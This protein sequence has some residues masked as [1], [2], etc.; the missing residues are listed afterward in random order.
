MNIATSPNTGGDQQQELRAV[1]AR[2]PQLS[3][4]QVRRLYD[5]VYGGANGCLH[6]PVSLGAT[7]EA[8][9]VSRTTGTRRPGWS[10]VSSGFPLMWAVRAEQQYARRLTAVAEEAAQ[11]AA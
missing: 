3:A 2:W 10:P 11:R 1:A 4:Q 7:V 8:N 6:P 9:G 5:L